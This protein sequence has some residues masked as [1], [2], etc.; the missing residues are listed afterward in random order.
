MYIVGHEIRKLTLNDGVETTLI[1]WKG[2]RDSP[3]VSVDYHY[4]DHL[5]YWGDRYSIHRSPPFGGSGNE[6]KCSESFPLSRGG[7]GQRGGRERGVEGE[8]GS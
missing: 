8:S 6:S 3:P 5:I 1:Y 7:E 2:L 4:N